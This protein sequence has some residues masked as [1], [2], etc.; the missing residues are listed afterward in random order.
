MNRLTAE[1]KVIEFIGEWV[2][3]YSFLPRTPLVGRS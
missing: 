1:Q 2:E 3:K